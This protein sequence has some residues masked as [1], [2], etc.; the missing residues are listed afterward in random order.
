MKLINFIQSLAHTHTHTH[1]QTHTE[2]QNKKKKKRTEKERKT[3]KKKRALHSH[4][5]SVAS[6][7]FGSIGQNCNKGIIDKFENQLL[8]YISSA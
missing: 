2:K 7:I 1:T 4:I 6:V 8:I 5:G 3:E